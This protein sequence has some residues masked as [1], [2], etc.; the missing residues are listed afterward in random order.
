MNTGKQVGVSIPEDFI[1][2]ALK[3]AFAFLLVA[4]IFWLGFANDDNGE[5]FAFYV[6]LTV[7]A[8][9]LEGL[10]A[11]A[12]FFFWQMQAVRNARWFDGNG[13]AVELSIVRNRVGTDREQP[14]DSMAVGIQYASGTIFLAV[15]VLAKFLHNSG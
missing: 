11:V 3:S 1:K 5:L 15:L 4:G 14:G 12:L 9:Q 8:A 7:Y 13:S 6:T 10:L 2:N